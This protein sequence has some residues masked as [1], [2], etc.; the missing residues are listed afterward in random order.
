MANRL[1]RRFGDFELDLSAYA[2]RWQGRRVRIERRPMDLLILL[3]ERRGELVTRAEIIERLWGSE[4]FVE[5]DVAINSAIR[6][7]RRAL[8][9]PADEPTYVETVQGKGY[10][11]VADVASPMRD[12]ALD[13]NRVTATM[14][15]RWSSTPS[16]RTRSR[17]LWSTCVMRLVGSARPYDQLGAR[18][19][20]SRRRDTPAIHGANLS[21]DLEG[22]W[23]QPQARRCRS[24][25]AAIEHRLEDDSNC[26]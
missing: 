20:H 26:L 6:K 5:V 4:V 10:R 23:P 25:R 7:V 9:D 24:G 21:A 13:D 19:A 18:G 15:W 3:V 12:T 16:A 22:G 1:I 2:L 14:K 17:R 11:F 8:R